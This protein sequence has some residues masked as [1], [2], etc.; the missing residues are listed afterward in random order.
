MGLNGRMLLIVLVLAG[1]RGTIDGPPPSRRDVRTR[2][3]TT[4]PVN[5]RPSAT[6]AARCRASPGRCGRSSHTTIVGA[7]ALADPHLRCPPGRRSAAGTSTS[8]SRRETESQ[9]CVE[10]IERNLS[11]Q[12]RAPTQL[13]AGTKARR[14]RTSGLRRG[15]EG[16]QTFSLNV[17]QV[18]YT[19]Q[20]F[21]AP[22]ESDGLFT[23]AVTC[24]PRS[25]RSDV[26]RPSDVEGEVPRHVT[27][28]PC[29]GT[30]R[31]RGGPLST[32]STSGPA[33]V[34]MRVHRDFGCSA[35]EEYVP[36]A[37]LRIPIWARHA[38]VVV[39]FD[40]HHPEP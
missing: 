28:M 11:Q 6:R 25:S 15:C 20:P 33:I 9:L 29:T 4:T 26:Q 5:F 35:G 32:R 13:A 36:E 19:L 18:A 8:G 37:L 39:A 1:L 34:M 38:I 24:C 7:F 31:P 2:S 23:T 14:R 12:P 40:P 3:E 16:L 30:Q 17:A 27:Q 21:G 10:P 22:S